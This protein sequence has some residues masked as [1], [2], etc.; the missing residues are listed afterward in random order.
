MGLEDHAAFEL[1]KQLALPD[2]D[3]D[4]WM[5]E[6][7]MEL[8][9]VFSAQGHSGS[10]APFCVKM[11]ETLANWRP[12]G[13]LTGEDD[14]W[15]EVSDGVFQNKRCSHVFRENGEAYDIDGIVF[16]DEHGCGYT[17]RD[18]RVPVTFPYTPT[19]RYV[20]VEEATDAVR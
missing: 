19:T 8:I 18:S 6:N 10:S 3:P 14:E 12:W 1:R 20:N 11:F 7:V 2:D 17:N 13:P 5:A 9:R 16:V 15:S 4:R